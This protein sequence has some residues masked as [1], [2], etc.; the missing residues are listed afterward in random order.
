MPTQNF[1]QGVASFGMPILGTGTSIPPTTGLVFFVQA[2]I[3][4]D[5]TNRGTD[6]LRPFRTINYAVTKCRANKGDTIL[7][8][9]G[10]SETLTSATS[11]VID[12]AGVRI[13]GLGDGA[14]RPTIL[15]GTATTATVVVSAASVTLRNLIFDMATG[16]LDAI[17]AAV[18]VTGSWFLCDSCRFLMADATYQGVVGISLGS[19]ANNARIWNADVDATAAAGAAE[20]VL[21]A[22]AISNLEIVG[23][24]VRGNFSNA[25][26]LYSTSSN[27]ITDLSIT[28]LPNS[29]VWQQ[30]GTSK[31]II[32]VTSSST[33]IVADG[34]WR[35][36]TW[37]SVA[38]PITNAT[39]LKFFENYGH[40]DVSGMVSGQLCPAAT[41]P[42]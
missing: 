32:D 34:R 16:A 11:L 4:T 13:I 15:F 17:A 2:T 33:G 10:H 7:V 5:D 20:F 27:H 22:A 42:A 35:G 9:P 12:K 37:S 21:A 1:P 28:G 25:A 38:D 31:R 19:G 3:G 29:Q 6:P 39:G 26:L 8:M 24:R 30:N 36:T 23:G 14:A 41:A 18:T 40:D